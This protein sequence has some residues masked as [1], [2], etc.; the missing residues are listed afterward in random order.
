MRFNKFKT[1]P[2]RNLLIADSQAKNL[3][4]PNFYILSLLG[5]Q[6]RHASHYIPQKG[7]HNTIVLFIGRNDLYY[8][9]RLA[10]EEPIDV[11]EELGKLAKE[12][13]L[14]AGITQRG[15]LTKRTVAANNLIQSEYQPEVAI[16]QNIARNT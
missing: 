5:E 8:D 2:R 11:A 4:F 1:S 6:I 14:V 10:V 3:F 12:L 13:E 15:E 7:V 9:D 16:P